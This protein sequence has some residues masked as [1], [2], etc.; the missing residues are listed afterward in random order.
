MNKKFQPTQTSNGQ[1]Q[2][3]PQQPQQQ[4]Q[5]KTFPTTICWMNNQPIILLLSKDSYANKNNCYLRDYYAL[6]N[7]WKM[8]IY[9]SLKLE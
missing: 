7:Y 9:N 1:Q 3:P 4:Q 2:Q 6:H 5:K 8:Q